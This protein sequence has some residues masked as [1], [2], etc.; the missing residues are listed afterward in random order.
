MLDTDRNIVDEPSDRGFR[1]PL[2]AF[3]LLAATH[4]GVVRIDEEPFSILAW[5]F[6]VAGHALVVTVVVSLILGLGRRS[7][8]TS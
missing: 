8:P 4:A 6:S 5:V 2:S 1:V 3:L 7:E